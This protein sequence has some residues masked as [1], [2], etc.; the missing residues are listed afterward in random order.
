M[1][2]KGEERNPETTPGNHPARLVEA[3]REETRVE[4]REDGAGGVRGG[5][6]LVK[7]RRHEGELRAEALGDE[8]RHGA[9]DAELPGVVVGR[10]DHA[11]AADGHGHGG[12]VG[13]VEL[14]H[15]AGEE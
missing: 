3:D 2:G 6:V 8:A 1:R 15:A 7:I 4:L 9:A 13:R 10:G 12:E 5:A 14:L 11:D